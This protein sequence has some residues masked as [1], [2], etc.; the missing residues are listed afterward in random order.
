MAK[1]KTVVS[2]VQEIINDTVKKEKEKDKKIDK[3]LKDIKRNI[4][5]K[6]GIIKWDFTIDDEI[7]FFDSELS[8][9]ITGYRPINETRGLDF[10]PDWF[11]K[12]RDVKN[13]TG[14]YT[15]APPRTKAY[16]DFWFEEYRRCRDGYTV[17]GYTI[18]GD[19][20]YFLNY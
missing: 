2:K 9:E 3:E 15:D 17:N 11:T 13:T 10:N 4:E 16:D 19:N 12:S 6:T 18:T 5:E 1:K 14:N 7:L 20:Y 8:Y